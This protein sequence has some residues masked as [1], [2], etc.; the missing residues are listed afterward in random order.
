VDIPALHRIEGTLQQLRPPRWPEDILGAVDQEKAARGEVLFRERCQECHGPHVAEPARMQASAPMK[1]VP[2]TEW[3]IEVIPLDHIG[4]DPT[5]AMRFMDRRYDLSRTGLTNAEL[6]DTL[7]PLLVRALARDVRFR[8]RELARMREGDAGTG[9]LS[10]V[11][12]AYPDPDAG[13]AAL[14]D[15]AFRS[16]EAALAQAFSPLP[17]VPAIDKKPNDYLG[18]AEKCHLRMLLWNLHHGKAAIDQRLGKID[19]T[20]LSEGAALNFVGLMVKNR[21]YAEKGIDYATQ[22]CLEGYGALDLPQELPGYKPRPLEGV[23]ATPPFLHNGSVPTIYQMLLPPDKRDKEF[24]VG[25]REYDPKNLGYETK[26]DADGNDDGFWL[27]T[28][29]LGNHNTGHAFAADAASWK[30]HLEDPKNNH[31]PEGVIGP[32]LTDDQRYDIIE[33][34]KI[35]RDLPETPADFQPPECRLPGDP[36]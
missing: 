17:E 34:L 29:K 6:A 32:E 16:I 21:Y 13:P 28:T 31:L 1:Q 36:A 20:S 12:A 4:T 8:I 10:L 14:P 18:C 27:D 2:G 25:R 35:H 33:Y 15:E 22:Q 11:A 23:W 7:R 30:K 19:V 3:R 9:P 5:A 26:P 24:F